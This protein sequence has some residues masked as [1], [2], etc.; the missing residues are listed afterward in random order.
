[1]EKLEGD[2][3]GIGVIVLNRV[4]SR[5][6]LSAQLLSGVRYAVEQVNEAVC[7]ALAPPSRVFARSCAP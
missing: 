2:D 4:A 5:N 7:G 3:A 6:A 1:M